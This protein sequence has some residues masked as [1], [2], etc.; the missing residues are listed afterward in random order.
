VGIFFKR[1]KRKEYVEANQQKKGFAKILKRKCGMCKVAGWT[2]E[3]RSDS[4]DAFNLLIDLGCE[5]G[6][7]LLVCTECFKA[8]LARYSC[9]WESL[10]Y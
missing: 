6:R 8:Y 9:R 3:I 4:N 10:V 2:S 1:I 5:D 7:A